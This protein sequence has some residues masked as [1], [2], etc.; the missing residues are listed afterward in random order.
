[1]KYIARGG[2]RSCTRDTV[3]RTRGRPCSRRY[4][5]EDS[6]STKREAEVETTSLP[7]LKIDYKYSD[8]ERERETQSNIAHY[9][10][11]RYDIDVI[12]VIQRDQTRQYT[13]N[14]Q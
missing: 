13:L 10:K 2:G 5:E 11:V 4:S 6:G 1:M 12:L 9:N 3:K 7:S 8:R 14:N